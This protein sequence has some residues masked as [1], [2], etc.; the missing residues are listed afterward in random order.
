MLVLPVFFAMDAYVIDTRNGYLYAHVDAQK[1]SA[2]DYV[3]LYSAS[4]EDLIKQN[5]PTI[6]SDT[7]TA[8]RKVFDA[9]RAKAVPVPVPAPPAAAARSA[10]HE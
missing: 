10:A 7:A 6:L 3:S 8:M 5:W 9:E 4:G 2:E 1:E